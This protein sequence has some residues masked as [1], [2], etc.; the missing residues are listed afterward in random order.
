MF[1]IS[2]ERFPE[3]EKMIYDLRKAGI[4]CAMNITPLI[5]AE[6]YQSYSILQEGLQKG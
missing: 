5:S 4:K 2:K 6:C 1:T 3:V